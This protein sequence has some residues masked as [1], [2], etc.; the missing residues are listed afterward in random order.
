MKIPFGGWCSTRISVSLTHYT[1]LKKGDGGGNTP[2]LGVEVWGFGVGG[3]GFSVWSLRT[4][5]LMVYG[6]GLM[7]QGRD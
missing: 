1:F 3:L 7:I 2:I 4:G 5:L 6:I